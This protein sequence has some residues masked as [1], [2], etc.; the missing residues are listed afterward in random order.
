MDWTVKVTDL[1][2]VFATFFGPVAALWMQRNIDHRREQHQRRLIIFRMLMTQR[3]RLTREHVDAINAVPL[4]FAEKKGP[5]GDV[6]TAWKVYL[7]HMAK[8]TEEPSWAATRV[9]LFVDLLQKM[10]RFLNYDFDPVELENEFYF[11]KGHVTLSSDQD[12]IRQG[13]AEVLTG[14]R[15]VPMNVNSFP[16]DPEYIAQ[17]RGVLLKLEGWLD[18]QGPAA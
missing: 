3:L 5:I 13:L 4:E 7:G 9:R 1:A 16:S 10:G 2:I 11:P 14:K 17:L 18:R 6:R 12:V 15:A 8:N